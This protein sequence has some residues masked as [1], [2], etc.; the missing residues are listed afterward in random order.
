M[1]INRYSYF[2]NAESLRETKL[3]YIYESTE[4]QDWHKIDP[5]LRKELRCESHIHR[6]PTFHL[7]AQD[8]LIS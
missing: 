4:H 8:Q 2:P 3:R 7:K 1:G 5:G 6:V